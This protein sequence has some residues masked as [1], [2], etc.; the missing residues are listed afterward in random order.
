VTQWSPQTPDKNHF[1]EEHE[2]QSI[3]WDART[4]SYICSTCGLVLAQGLHPNPSLESSSMEAKGRIP[5]ESRNAWLDREIVQAGSIILEQDLMK[6]I[7]P[8]QREL[9]HRLYRTQLRVISSWRQDRRRSEFDRFLQ[10]LSK[11]K[12]FRTA[13]PPK[14]PKMTKLL[15]TFLKCCQSYAT[16]YGRHHGLQNSTK[17]RI[18]LVLIQPHLNS[19]IFREIVKRIGETN[20]REVYEISKKIGEWE[21]NFAAVNLQRKSDFIDKAI[22]LVK[23]APIDP[24]TKKLSEDILTKRARVNGLITR[25]R[26]STLAAAAIFVA[27]SH[28]TP[29]QRISKNKAQNL[30]GASYIPTQTIDDCRKILEMD[31]KGF[32]R[33]ESQ[34]LLMS[35]LTQ[36]EELLATRRSLRDGLAEEIKKAFPEFGEILELRNVSTLKFLEQYPNTVEIAK[37]E[38]DELTNFLKTHSKGKLRD[39]DRLATRLLSEARKNETVGRRR[40]RPGNQNA[41]RSFVKALEKIERQRIKLEQKMKNAIGE[42]GRVLIRA[43]GIGLITATIMILSKHPPHPISEHTSADGKS[44]FHR[45]LIDAIRVMQRNRQLRNQYQEWFDQKVPRVEAILHVMA[46]L[47]QT[48][49]LLPTGL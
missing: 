17:I 8:R 15:D 10:R 26:P 28:G 1:H 18:F 25:K 47:L 36:R 4:E 44:L 38:L 41:I 22:Q 35:S 29:E 32:E 27:A 31:D 49:P 3:I 21:S 13:F 11:Y 14:H 48:T 7:N 46:K 23:E 5:T 2:H 30:V 9:F 19:K 20:M 33:T 37:L 43:P 42:E 24:E 16:R 34:T 39:V 12:A 45:R 40:P 6:L